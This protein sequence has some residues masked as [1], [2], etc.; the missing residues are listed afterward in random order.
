MKHLLFL[1]FLAISLSSFAQHKKEIVYVGTY[2]VRGSEGIYV[3]EFDRV[4]GRLKLIQTIETRKSPNFIAIH[5]SGKFLYTV[6]DGPLDE[7]KNSG[8]VSSY[9]IDPKTGKITLLNERPSYGS[10]PCHISIDKT[11]KWVFVSN[12]SEGNF[13]V[14]PIFD[15]GLLGSSSDSRKHMGSSVNQDRQQRA[16]VHATFVAPDNG[17]VAVCDLGLDKVYS[18]KLNV[19][20]GRIEDAE[21]P[22]VKVTPGA[23]PRHLS[24]HPTKPYAYLA[25]ELTSTVCVCAYD[26]TTGGLTILQDSVISLPTTFKGENTAADIHTSP[27]GKFLYMSCRGHDALEIFKIG[28]QGAIQRIG[29]QQ[30]KGKTPRNFMIDPKGE[31]IFVANQQGDNVVL[32][33][34]NQ[35]TGYLTDIGR[36][37]KVPSPVCIKML[38][39]P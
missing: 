3:Y 10:E 1:F 5:P 15:D 17:Y 21:K 30:T 35:R 7:M 12:Y 11:G 2:S 37:Y 13:V 4:K 18:Y 36:Q 9:K 38:T 34:A 25:E 23:G 24:F 16:H 8:S 27:N 39:L 14:L 6:N 19:D 31:Y 22:F 33:R 28:E 26:K 20:D 29:H 32:F